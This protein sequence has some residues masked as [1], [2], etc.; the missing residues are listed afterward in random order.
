MTAKELLILGGTGE[1]AVLARLTAEASMAHELATG[2]QRYEL[3]YA[4]S[5]GRDRLAAAYN[6]ARR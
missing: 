2:E 4:L 5:A 6:R 3:P 1:A